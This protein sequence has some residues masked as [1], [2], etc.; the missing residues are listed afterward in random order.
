MV[1][2]LFAISKSIHMQYGHPCIP[3]TLVCVS[4]E[5]YL[6]FNDVVAARLHQPVTF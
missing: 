2:L 1:D 6:S 4:R 3:K 5:L